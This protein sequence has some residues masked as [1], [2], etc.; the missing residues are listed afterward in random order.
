MGP[1]STLSSFSRL[2]IDLSVE[3]MDVDSIGVF[4][5]L[6]TPSWT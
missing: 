2:Q 5:R 4:R 3:G 6:D 1:E